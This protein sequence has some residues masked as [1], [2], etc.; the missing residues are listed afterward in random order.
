MCSNI[1]DDVKSCEVFRLIKNLNIQTSREKKIFF[2]KWENSLYMK[3]YNMV[4]NS[5]LAQVT[6]QV[7]L[8]DDHYQDFLGKR[9]KRI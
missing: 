9:I 3:G 8:K 4:K 1:Y 7:A 2:F 5:F 6:F